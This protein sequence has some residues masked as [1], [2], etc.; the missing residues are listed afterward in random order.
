[1]GKIG[2]EKYPSKQTV[3][4]AACGNSMENTRSMVP[5]V[6]LSV[7]LLAAIAGYCIIW[8][9]TALHAVQAE[10]EEKKAE[11]SRYQEYNMDYYEIEEAYRDYFCTYLTEEEAGLADHSPIVK[12]LEE[13]TAAYGVVDY[14]T[15]QEDLCQVTIEDVPF[16]AVAQLAEELES[17]PLILQAVVSVETAG[18]NNSDE[19]EIRRVT[20]EFTMTLASPEDMKTGQEDAGGARAS[21]DKKGSSWQGQPDTITAESR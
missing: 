19:G 11:L 21:G 3:N 15:I 4:L 20:A 5:L 7:A 17:D 18:E 16:F 8:P 9:V 12:L 13:K 6:V 2:K 10:L 14:V 1:M